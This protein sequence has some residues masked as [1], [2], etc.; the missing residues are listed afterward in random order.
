[1]HKITLFFMVLLITA[2]C[3]AA[4]VTAALYTTDGSNKL[5]GRVD[6]RDTPLGL[7]IIPNLIALPAGL[8]G[9][10]LHQNANCNDHGMSAGGHFD[11]KNTNTHQGPYENGHLGDLPVLYVG[12]DGQAHTK[13]LAPRLKTSDIKGLAMMIHMGGDNYTDNPPL[14]GGGARIACGNIEDQAIGTI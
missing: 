1:M 9:F 2:P 5:L 13:T 12:T 6:F 10:H 3:Q 4:H 11:P 8:H 14:G 7:L